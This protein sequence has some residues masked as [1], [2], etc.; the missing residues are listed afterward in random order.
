MKAPQQPPAVAPDAPPFAVSYLRY[1][2]PDQ[3][4]GDTVRRQT[5]DSAAWCARN[6]VPLT[7]TLSMGARGV[8][9]FKGRHRGDKEA[10]GRFLKLV[11]DGQVPRGSYLILENLDRLSREHIRPALAL[12]LN[13]IEGGV[14][15][16]QL[17]PFEQVFDDT[18][19]PMQLMMAIMELSRGHS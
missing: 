2:D 6:G 15:V 7:T 11:E 14:R 1:S 9:A 17:H 16:V 18:V 10:L 4:K 3:E 19:E 5:A 8:S 12:L 13:L